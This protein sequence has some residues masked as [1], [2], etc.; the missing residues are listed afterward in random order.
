MSVQFRWL[1]A[2][3]SDNRVVGAEV[4]GSRGHRMKRVVFAVAVIGFG[5]ALAGDPK[6]DDGKKQAA[7]K[8]L[9]TFAGTWEIAAVKPEGAT[10]EA[11]KLVFRKDRTYAALDK[12]GKELWAGTFEIDPTATPKVWDHRS[13]EAKTKGGD[14]LGIYELAGDTLKVSCV[15]GTWKGKEWAGKSRPKGFDPKGADVMI[16]MRRVKTG[17]K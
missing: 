4:A 17:E 5:L 9:E 14:V 13:H 8:A 3:P 2:R 16:E 10:K 12:D 6:P 1:T 7:E 11:R 15:V